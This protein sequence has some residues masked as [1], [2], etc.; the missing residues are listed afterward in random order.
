MHLSQGKNYFGS[1]LRI[2][3]STRNYAAGKGLWIEPDIT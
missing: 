2:A 3:I 1:M